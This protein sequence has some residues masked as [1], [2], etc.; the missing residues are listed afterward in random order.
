MDLK[1]AK[2][3]FLRLQ[4]VATPFIRLDRDRLIV[5][6]GLSGAHVITLNPEFRMMLARTEE[7]AL[8]DPK[9][10]LMALMNLTAGEFDDLVAFCSEPRTRKEILARAPHSYPERLE[11]AEILK[12]VGMRGQAILRVWRGCSLEPLLAMI[13]DLIHPAVAMDERLRQ[14]RERD[15]RA[16]IREGR[17]AE[18]ALPPDPTDHAGTIFF[19]GEI[20]I[21]QTEKGLSISVPAISC[22]LT[23]AQ[24][25][26]AV[27]MILRFQRT[28]L[29]RALERAARLKSEP[30][31]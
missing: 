6:T 1:N 26:E 18:A 23:N 13:D 12:R 5:L 21:D 4:R 9:T 17:S 22:P 11:N 2:W 24:A 3:G 15:R 16:E 7:G 20:A 28:C 29:E 31:K 25:D 27:N 10:L 8:P 19:Q 30:E 14:S